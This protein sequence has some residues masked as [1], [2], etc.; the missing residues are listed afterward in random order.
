M[1]S[2]AVEASREG[3]ESFAALAAALHPSWHEATERLANAILCVSGQIDQ[4]RECKDAGGNFVSRCRSLVTVL[5]D[6]LDTLEPDPDLE[7]EGEREREDGEPDLG[8]LDRMTDQTRW[9]AGCTDEREQDDCDR[10][11]DDPQEEQQQPPEMCP[12]A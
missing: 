6:V 8:S 11:D 2:N 10:E 1:K 9:S 3:L 5:I 4:I 7:D 12:C